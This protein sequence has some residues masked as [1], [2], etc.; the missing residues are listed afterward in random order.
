MHT[1]DLSFSVGVSLNFTRNSTFLKTTV[2]LFC[3]V[4]TLLHARSFPFSGSGA[5]RMELCVLHQSRSYNVPF[6][7][8]RFISCKRCRPLWVAALRLS[9]KVQRS[10][11]FTSSSASFVN[12]GRVGSVLCALPT[13]SSGSCKSSAGSSRAGDRR[14]QEDASARRRLLRSY[15]TPVRWA[16]WLLPR[17]VGR[18]PHR[19]QRWVPLLTFP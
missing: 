12:A 16:A 5:R 3:S 13:R 11:T 10:I 17:R 18:R 4:A 2:D 15:P 8:E 6:L 19:P 7:A 1:V 9:R 14:N